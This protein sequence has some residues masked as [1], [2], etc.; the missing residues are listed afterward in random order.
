[1]VLSPAVAGPV[2]GFFRSQTILSGQS[3]ASA[4]VFPCPCG[5]P[6][7]AKPNRSSKRDIVVVARPASEAKGSPSVSPA[8]PGCRVRLLCT[9]MDD[10]G[11]AEEVD[12]RN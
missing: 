3:F 4:I 9:A 1:M 2:R 12:S 7:A 6:P 5:P 10:R 11:G 8:K